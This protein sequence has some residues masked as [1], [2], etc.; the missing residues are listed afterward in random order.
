M[1][2]DAFPMAFDEG[3]IGMKMRKRKRETLLKKIN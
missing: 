2:F 1:A 3:G